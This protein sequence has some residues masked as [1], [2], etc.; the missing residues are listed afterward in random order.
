MNA[1]EHYLHHL[2]ATYEAQ[3]RAVIAKVP[4]PGEFTRKGYRKDKAVWVDYTGFLCTGG[5]AIVLEAK[6]CGD[7]ESTRVSFPVMARL[8]HIQA[9]RL[10]QAARAG[11]VSAV[12]V[13]KTWAG[14]RTA[15]Y[16]IPA[17]VITGNLVFSGMGMGKKS[18]KWADLEPWQVPNEHT[19]LDAVT[20]RSGGVWR[21]DSY[22]DHGWA[23][24]EP[25]VLL[26]TGT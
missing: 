11:A 7:T 16:L 6:Q 4:T 2:H 12:Y 24:V 19:W 21:W 26:R 3:K 23:A 14:L 8:E 17:R 1:L 9:V 5:K 13:R 15:D 22:I 10:A 20:S 25:R 18:I